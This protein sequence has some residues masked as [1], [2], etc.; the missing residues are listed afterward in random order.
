MLFGCQKGCSHTV[1]SYTTPKKLFKEGCSIAHTPTTRFNAKH[2]HVTERD[3][4]SRKCIYRFQSLYSI[5]YGPISSKGDIF[6][7]TLPYIYIQDIKTFSLRKLV[8]Y[9]I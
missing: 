1:K 7:E 8:V 2:G 5:I 3:V 9:R 4:T 6:A